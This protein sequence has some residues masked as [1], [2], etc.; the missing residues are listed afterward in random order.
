MIYLRCY[1]II[2]LTVLS[3]VKFY[4][5]LSKIKLMPVLLHKL[6]LCQSSAEMRNDMSITED[7]ATLKKEKNAVI[8]AH[9]YVD[10]DVQNIAD[11]VGDSFYLSKIATNQC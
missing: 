5:I 8:L 2:F 7:I 6:K 11:Y 1:K 10:E 9:Y 3:S 4:G